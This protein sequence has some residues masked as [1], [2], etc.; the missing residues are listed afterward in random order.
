[1]IA[2]VFTRGSIGQDRTVRTGLSSD[3]IIASVKGRDVCRRRVKVT[4]ISQKP[5]INQ[6]LKVKGC[7]DFVE[8]TTREFVWIAMV[9]S[10]LIVN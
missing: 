7:Q 1:M 10:V 4:I 9:L 6:P 2:A 3:L 8:D 5:Q